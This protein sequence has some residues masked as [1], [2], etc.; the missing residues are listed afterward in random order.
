MAQSF[1]IPTALSY[2]GYDL[3]DTNFVVEPSPVGD[4]VSEWAKQGTRNAYGNTGSVVTIENA[5]ADFHAATHQ[6]VLNKSLATVYIPSSELIN[7]IPTLYKLIGDKAPFVFH[8]PLAHN[9]DTSDIFAIRQTGA[10]LIASHGAQQA[11][12]VGLISHIVALRNHIPVVHFYADSR[13]YEQI[14]TIQYSELSNL[15]AEQ[16]DL[17]NK[18]HQKNAEV[19][20]SLFLPSSQPSI[21]YTQ[22]TQ[23]F[24]DVIQQLKPA[25]GTRAYKLFEY[26]GAHDATDVIVVLGTASS[27]VEETVHNLVVSGRKVGVV[28]VRVYRPWSEEHFLAALPRTVRRVSVLETAHTLTTAW[29]PLFLDVAA[30]FHSGKWQGEAPAVREG[31]VHLGTEG[32]T[33][34]IVKSA[35]ERTAADEQ[36]TFVIGAPQANGHGPVT[37]SVNGTVPHVDLDSVI[38][39]PYVKMLHQLF[40]ERVSIANVAAASS[41]WGK[42]AAE[43]NAEFGFGMHLAL[44]QRRNRFANGLANLVKDASADVPLSA[45]LRNVLASWLQHR[46]DAEKSHKY[47]NDA[48]HLL[49]TEKSRHPALGQLYEDRVFFAKPSRWLIGGDQLSYD[50]GNS[51]VHHVISSKENINMIVLDTQPYSEKVAP[52]QVDKRKKDIG[53]YAMQYGGVYVASVAVNASYAQVLRAFM[54]ADAYPGPAVVLAYAPRINKAS[55]GVSIPLGMLKETKQA[56]DSGYWPLYRWNPS[57]EEKGQDPFALDSE[58]VKKEIFEFLER[59]NH[60]AYVLKS[61]PEISEQFTGS[62]ESE[63]KAAIENKIKASYAELLSSLNTQPLLV[64]YGSDGGNAEAVAKRVGAE[65]KQ[66]GLRPR[67]MAADSYSVEDLPGEPNVVFVVSTAGQGEFPGNCKE[68]WKALSSVTELDLSKTRFAVLALGDRHYW[69]LPEDKHYFAKAGKDLDAKLELLGAPRLTP[70]GIGDDQD[71]D[72]YHTG[73]NLWRPL[74]WK[75]LDVDEMDVSLEPALPSDDAIKESSNFLRGTIAEG[76]VN[77]STGALVE[78]DTKL[79]KFHGIYQQDD[80]DI[81]DERARQGFEPAFSFMVRCRIP[82]GTITPRQ[83]LAVDDIADRF[84]NGT[85]KITTRQTFQFHGIVKRVLK[86]SIREMNQALMDTIAACGDVNR[87]VLCSPNEH[88]SEVN[89]A[90]LKLA[91]DWSTHML[92]HSGA[93][94]EIWLDKKLVV[95]TQEEHEPIYGKTFL[96]RKFKTAIAVPPHNDVDI[97]ANDLGYIAI[98]ENGK[99]VGYNVTVGGGMG[100]TH[101]NKKTYPRLADVLGFCTPEQAIEVGEKVVTVQRD[102]GDRTNRKHARLKYTIDDRSIEWFRGEVEKRLGWKLPAPRPFKFDSNGDRFGWIQES[103]GSWAYT[104]F[105]QSGRVK[106]TPE[107]RMKTALKDLAKLLDKLN[108]GEIRLTANQH[109][110]IA[111]IPTAHRAEIDSFLRTHKLL[112]TNHSGLRLNSMAC[113][114]LPTCGLAMAESERY[115]PSLM[116]LIEEIL[117]EHGLR[118]DAITIRMTGCPN[119]C[120]RPTIAEIGFVGKAPGAYNMYLGGGFVGDRLSKL[121]R[122]SIG[123]EEII[124]EL[125]PLLARY[126]RDRI[127]GEKFGDWVIRAGVVK[128]TRAGK[129]FHD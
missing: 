71:P 116:T 55:K 123:E 41:V 7:T 104:M 75:A 49:E 44:V 106:D 96:P 89:E 70:L 72:G 16:K 124:K 6:A 61:K 52:A 126:A 45:E 83:W 59:E 24:V 93:Y 80:R 73:L 17:V 113:V 2:V 46:D 26:T 9:G 14:H 63:R 76:L 85:I 107:H 129:D 39:G 108:I 66:R 90:V 125:R 68:T 105:I 67:V 10:L 11:H 115:L 84:A 94:H 27:T 127:H 120:A 34:E 8:T 121:Y 128:A 60:L 95:S 87:N 74:L 79:I 21:D 103:N 25:F 4:L 88:S 92:P 102:Y 100:M 114:A 57:L 86:P 54:E 47:G 19:K 81:R 37:S 48:V 69:P 42:N 28:R 56:V 118:D 18:Y 97:F 119:G 109:L 33:G 65:A 5:R 36:G 110:L 1:N 98:I 29:G 77:S 23:S 58:K 64:L 111:K 122:E 22:I 91:R 38:E 101:G 20:D 78:L 31:R 112:I 51:G 40:G 30:S 3:A 43:S 32:F 117:D 35:L 53:L 15:F 13:S 62:A 12:D 82:G 50:V 99:I